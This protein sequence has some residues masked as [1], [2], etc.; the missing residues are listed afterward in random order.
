MRLDENR[1]RNFAHSLF[2]SQAGVCHFCSMQPPHL[3]T[4]RVGYRL[5]AAIADDH[6]RLAASVDNRVEFAGETPTADRCVS[7][8]RQALAGAAVIDLQDPESSPVGI[9]S[10]TVTMLNR[11]FG[12][13]IAAIFW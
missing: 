12:N 4:S 6:R 5:R 3:T 10:A 7:H 9:W 2:G 11:Y 1:V 8:Q 13:S